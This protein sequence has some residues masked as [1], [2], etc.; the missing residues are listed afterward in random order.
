MTPPFTI[1]ASITMD[2][3]MTSF[4]NILG[5][6]TPN[7]NVF[8]REFRVTPNKDLEYGQLYGGGWSSVSGQPQTSF[9]YNQKY[10]VAVV[11]LAD[12]NVYLY[13]DGVEIVQGTLVAEDPGTTNLGTS[14]GKS[15]RQTHDCDQDFIGKIENLKIYDVDMRSSIPSLSAPCRGN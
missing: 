6:G 11:R 9:Q 15:C 2:T 4:G 14:I 7:N 1:F 12:N 5:F 10:D 13:V 3:G 8:N